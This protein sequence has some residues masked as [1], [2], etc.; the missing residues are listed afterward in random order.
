M[1]YYHTQTDSGY[2]IVIPLTFRDYKVIK[3]IGKGS[4]AA[5]VEVTEINTNIN[6]AAKIIPKKSILTSD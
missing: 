6:Y 4:F 1:N 2:P 5:V 3:T